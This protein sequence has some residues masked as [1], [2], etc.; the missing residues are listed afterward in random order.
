M[1]LLCLKFIFSLVML[2]WMNLSLVIKP[3]LSQYKMTDCCL[4]VL[5]FNIPVNNFSVMSGQSHCLL[6][7]TSTLG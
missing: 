2:K 6:V 3:V 1:F 4:F 7:I 5:R